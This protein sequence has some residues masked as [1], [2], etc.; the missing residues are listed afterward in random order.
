[1]SNKFRIL[2]QIKLKSSFKGGDQSF[3]VHLN[4]V[5]DSISPVKMYLK[6]VFDI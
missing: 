3:Y 6:F 5:G 2:L 1:M 4:V